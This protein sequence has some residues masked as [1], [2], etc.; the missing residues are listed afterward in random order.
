MT[1]HPTDIDTLLDDLGGALHR[2]R[3]RGRRRSRRLATATATV[4]TLAVAFGFSYGALFGPAPPFR[5]LPKPFRLPAFSGADLRSGK[6]TGTSILAGKAGFVIV[7]QSY[8]PPCARGMSGLNVFVLGHS[9][10]P[11][12]GLDVADLPAPAR[13]LIERERI[14]FPS[15]PLPPAVTQR[16]EVA[17]YPSILAVDPHGKV[18]AIAAGATSAHALAS[19]LERL[20]ARH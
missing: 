11:V 6:A 20:N 7:W 2:Y 15:I 17:G 19:E 9:S 5:A 1:E 3:A 14:R 18:V 4:A 16:L 12:L 8:C 10:I 13:T